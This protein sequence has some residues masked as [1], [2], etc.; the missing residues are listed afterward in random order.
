MPST[1]PQSNKSRA[2]QQSCPMSPTDCF[3]ALGLDPDASWTTIRQTYKDLVRVWHPDRF[4]SDPGLQQRAEQRLLLINHAYRA[5]REWRMAGAA[6]PPTAA[7]AAEPS[8]PST[9]HPAPPAKCARFR[10]RLRFRWPMRM[11]WAVLVS[12]SPL[13]LGSLILSAIQLPTFDSLALP[14]DPSRRALP[15]PSAWARDAALDLF[16][17]MPTIG[18]AVTS[19]TSAP[20]VQPAPPTTPRNGAE[21]LRTHMHGGSELMVSNPTNRDAIAKLVESDK[22]S[23][24]R[25]VYI[26]AKS[27][28]AILHIAPGQYDLLAEIGADWDASHI[29]FKKDRLALP[30]CGP[31]Q[32]ID[33]TSSRGTYGP[34]FQIVLGRN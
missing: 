34:K 30:R 29:R 20:L 16:A 19:Q 18:G 22:T 28:A 11:V 7:E 32:C 2:T 24:V 6:A 8:P 15:A 21:L 3:R 13:A 5:L 1:G 9:V 25:M 23:P 10:L 27:E 31:F 33:V 17:A 26:Q 12:L 4:L 14:N